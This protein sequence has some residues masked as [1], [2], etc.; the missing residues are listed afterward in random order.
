MILIKTVIK[1]IKTSFLLFITPLS[2][3]LIFASPEPTKVLDLESFS[4]VI[5][6]SYSYKKHTGED[7]FIGE[8]VT[9]KKQSIV[10]DFSWE[11][12][13]N[14]LLPT[15]EEYLQTEEWMPS[16]PFC[17]H[18]V[19]YT[20]AEHVQRVKAREMKERGIKDS[21]LVHVEPFIRPEKRIS[22]PTPEQ[23]IK[24]SQ[25]DY[26]ATLTNKDSSIIIPVSIPE[27]VK[28]HH[29]QVDTT[30]AYFI[31]TI[32]PKA[33]GKGMT[34]LYIR[35]RKNSLTFN[36]VGMNLDEKEQK[37]VLEAFA[38]VRVRDRKALK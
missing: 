18:G 6:K 24:Y 31:K 10:F 14:S 13:A 33:G 22:L 37:E 7:S 36:I 34:G 15:A 11:G 25:A 28:Q 35:G 8:L 16:C 9:T 12:Y 3:I 30:D 32:Y 5:P 19:Q 26:I 27:V 38:T 1:K 29:I 21:S 17:V 23:R 4:I 2:S 20:L